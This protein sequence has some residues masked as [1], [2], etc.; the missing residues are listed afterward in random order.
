[1]LDLKQLGS[2][3]KRYREQFSQTLNEVSEGTGIATDRLLAYEQGEQKPSGDDILILADYFK[4][5]YIFFISN[6]KTAPFEQTENLYRRYS[7]EF[8]KQDR[9]AVQEFLYLCACEEFLIK[10]NEKFNARK[11]N[12]FSFKKTGSYYKGHGEEAAASLRKHLGYTSRKVGLD[13]FS[14]FRSI[15]FHLFRR[16]LSNSNISGLFINHPMA[17]LCILVNYEEDLYR[18]R[19]TA[20]HEAGHAI[21][22]SDTAETIVSF[23]NKKDLIET[24]ANV[25]AS[26]FLMPKEALNNIPDPN[27][28]DE[29]KIITWANSLKVSVEALSIALGQH[30]LISEQ[31]A[32]YFAKSTRV[33]KAMKTD[34]ELPD[35]LPSSILERKRTLLQMGLSKYYVDLCFDS[36]EMGIISAARL[37]ETLLAHQHEIADI[38]IM[39][40]RKMD[41]GD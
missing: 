20:A 39:Y 40:G 38:A 30:G 6:E 17:G 31:Q 35:N 33:P 29:T 26:N 3:L 12:F 19:F 22:D 23:R 37:A 28:W 18:Q 25:F 1:M 21:L 27:H 4:C 14:E 24:R 32:G 5:D 15:G 9:W 36:Y 8:E 41:Y 7:D 13:V 10:E 11:R 34:P 2:K 16:R